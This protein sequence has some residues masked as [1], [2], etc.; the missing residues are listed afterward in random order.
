VALLTGEATPTQFTDE[1]VQNAT[2]RALREK[3]FVTSDESVADHESFVAVEF[4]DGKKIEVHIENAIGSY[5]KP[6][7]VEFLKSKFTEQVGKRIGKER[8]E[9][10]YEA[11]SNVA[12][13]KDVSE[14]A[15]SYKA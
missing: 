15:R 13:V 4:A 1:M 5:E 11:F 14:L 7:T 10:A 8:A 2:V 6:L 3:V 12:N 9:K